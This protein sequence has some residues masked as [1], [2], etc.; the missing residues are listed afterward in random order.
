MT[1]HNLQLAFTLS[2]RLSFQSLEVCP[3]LWTVMTSTVNDLFWLINVHPKSEFSGL[4]Y[5]PGGA[6]RFF[7]TKKHH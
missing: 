7:P 6:S 5:L 2:A 1:L 3:Y 4:S